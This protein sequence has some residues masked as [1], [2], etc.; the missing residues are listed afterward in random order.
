MSFDRALRVILKHEGGYV[1]HPADP[2]GR[3]NLG[4]TLRVWVVWS[5]RKVGEAEMRALTPTMVAPLY[6]KNY[7]DKVRGDDLPPGVVEHV[8]A[9]LLPHLREAQAR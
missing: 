8:L 7:W 5:D 4:V 9:A 1:N 6:R 2:G 3:T